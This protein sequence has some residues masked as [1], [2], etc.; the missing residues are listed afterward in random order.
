VAIMQDNADAPPAGSAL[1]SSRRRRIW[2]CADDYGISPS[3]NAAIRDLVVRGRINASSVMVVAPTFTRSEALSLGILNAGTR[4]VAI[5]LHVTLTSP[6]RPLA[7]DFAP[8]VDGAF[9][10]FADLMRNSFL[11]R[12][13]R[14]ALEREVSAQL[15]AFAA[16]FGHPPDF[17]DGHRHVHLLPQVRDA[18]LAI[19]K[20]M[21]PRAWVRQCT[22]AG[23]WTSRL[24]DPKGLVVEWLSRG[25]ARRARRLGI[26]TNAAFA[27]TYTFR[28]DADFATLFPRFVAAMRD[29]GLIMCHPGRVDAELERLD[30]VTTLREREYAYLLGDAFPAT[31]A[32]HGVVLH[33]APP[34]L[35][36]QGG[37]GE[38]E[39]DT[40]AHGRA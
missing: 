4:R 22:G 36:P 35:P 14:A 6:F 8:R 21:S 37:P 33:E 20:E 12:L 1:D 29:D 2:L 25:L 23:A 7:K 10:S 38:P 40:T 16:A 9:P 19:A 28:A 5:G 27:G 39:Q 18:V 11:R 31:L 30:P 34:N 32:A 13:D 15:A 26:P 17:I 24:S 3:V